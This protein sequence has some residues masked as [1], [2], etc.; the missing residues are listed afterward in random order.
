VKKVNP[1]LLLIIF[2]IL[3][4]LVRK[5][6]FPDYSDAMVVSALERFLVTLGPYSYL[7][8]LATFVVCAF[9]FIPILMPMCLLCGAFYGP[10]TGAIIALVGIT[11]SCIVSTFSVRN[12]FRGMG[13]VVMNNQEY[14]KI[15]IK[16]TE[17]GTVVVLI[18]RMAFVVPYMLQNILLALT[19]ISIGRLALLTLIGAIPG[20]LSFSFLGAG[21]VSLGDTDLYGLMVLIPVAVLYL[22]NGVVNF[23]RNKH[24]LT[25]D[26]DLPV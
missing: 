13:G 4:F 23:L 25:G 16:M 7:Y 6:F 2:S 14:K 11:L 19:N 3:V 10:L 1:V 22:V 20:A 5:F 26:Q 17:Y 12:V 18:V 21:L 9:F 15:L 24:G 8:M